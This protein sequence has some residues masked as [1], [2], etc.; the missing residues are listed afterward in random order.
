MMER[1]TIAAVPACERH[2]DRNDDPA[3][4][5]CKLDAKEMEVDAAEAAQLS[6]QRRIAELSSRLERAYSAL[7]VCI[8][9]FER[10]ERGSTHWQ[11]CEQQHPS[12]RA[13]RTAWEA[14]SDDGGPD[15][16][17]GPWAEGWEERCGLAP[18]GGASE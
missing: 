5:W 14:L 8:D 13:M 4:P 12:C 15:Q 18:R 3:C 11:G 7:R 10:V 2:L 1:P 6:L 16:E 9:A 17:D